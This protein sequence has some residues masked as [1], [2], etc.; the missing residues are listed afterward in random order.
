MAH[1]LKQDSCHNCRKALNNKP[2]YIHHPVLC[3]YYHSDG[4]DQVKQNRDLNLAKGKIRT[5]PICP[6]SSV[7]R[8]T[9]ICS[10][11]RGFE[12]HRG[13]AFFL[14]F[15]VGPFPF[16]GYRSE[17]IILDQIIQQ[18]NLPHLD[19][20]KKVRQSTLSCR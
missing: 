18:F 14:F 3:S 16:W 11:G 1:L 12:L 10:G 6:C 19:D 20:Y 15:L 13:K 5:V 2:F 7:G 4:A 9:V 8:A 17:G